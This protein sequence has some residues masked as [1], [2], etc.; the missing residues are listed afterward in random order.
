MLSS[1]TIPRNQRFHSQNDLLNLK[2]MNFCEENALYDFANFNS[3][4]P[5]KLSTSEKCD[6]I[7]CCQKV[8]ENRA[9]TAFQ[10]CIGTIYFTY[11]IQPFFLSPFLLWIVSI[12]KRVRERFPI[13]SSAFPVR[14]CEFS[15]SRFITAHTAQYTLALLCP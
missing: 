9:R 8:T 1:E 12:H 6:N 2:C 13:C 7:N 15:A 14:V 4:H 11:E 5:R 10:H 3:S